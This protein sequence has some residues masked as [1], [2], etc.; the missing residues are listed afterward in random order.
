MEEKKMSDEKSVEI[1]T[2]AEYKK[3]VAPLCDL[4][5]RT[6]KEEPE[7]KDLA[8]L[9][10]V[11]RE[12][13]LWDIAGD[14]AKAARDKIMLQVSKSAL[15]KESVRAWVDHIRSELGYESAPMLEKLLIDQVAICCLRLY[16]IELDYSQIRSSGPVTLD[17]GAYYE[18]RLSA[19]QG[20]F[21]RACATLAR[22]R[23]I[24]RRTPELMQLNIGAQQVNVAQ[25]SED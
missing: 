4:I 22:I 6:D 16:H 11:F 24:A 21:L 20:R 9:R 8:A 25:V 13:E 7:P 23:K 12:T 14:L 5:E 17:V 3:K 2:E 10:R 1:Y 19:A 15:V 18:R